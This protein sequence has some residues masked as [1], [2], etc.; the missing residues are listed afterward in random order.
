MWIPC[1]IYDYCFRFS[2]TDFVSRFSFM[3]SIY[4]LT[5][6]IWVVVLDSDMTR[7][8]ECKCGDDKNDNTSSSDS[9]LAHESNAANGDNSTGCTSNVAYITDVRNLGWRLA[10]QRDNAYEGGF[11]ETRQECWA[12]AYTDSAKEIMKRAIM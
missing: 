12:S 5:P 10:F 9:S 6:F 2:F 8:R 3:I 7:L 11:Q 1:L 4:L